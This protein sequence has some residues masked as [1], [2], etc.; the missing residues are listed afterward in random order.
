MKPLFIE[1]GVKNGHPEEI[2]NKI[3][4]D[5]EAF[6]AYA[7]NKS[8]STCYAYIAYQTAYLK[9]H[10]PAEYMASV[11]SNNM[12]D[13]KAIAFFMEEA[14]RMGIKVLG[15]DVNESYYKF[16]VNQEGAIRFGMGAIKGMGEKAV[17]AIINERKKNGKITS[18][19]DMAKRVDLRAASKKAFDGLAVSGGFDGFGNINRSQYYAIDDKGLTILEKA[20]RFGNKFQENKN[21]AQISMFGEASEVQFDEPIIPFCEEWNV[22]EKLS[23]EKEA[24]GMYISGHPLDDYKRELK[25]FCN[26]DISY[27]SKLD[28]LI[29]RDL[30]FGGIV[31]NVQHRISKNGKGWASFVMEDYKE[32]FEFRI[33]GEDYLKFKHFLIP[34]AFLHIKIIVQRGWNDG[35][36]RMNYNNVQM[37]QDILSK[38]AKKITVNIDIDTLT[39]K[40]INVLEDLFIRH[41]G[42]HALHFIVYDK[43]RKLKLNMP[44]RSK[45]VHITTEFLKEMDENLVH[46]K[47]N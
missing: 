42:K 24:I 2:L 8:H 37:L 28:D 39:K 33:F 45:K 18:I 3:W 19:F 1:G 15:P 7:F 17:E 5:W 40:S 27:M 36:A 20:I 30:T 11:L 25:H 44:S 12:R 6:A 46:Y 26:A 14:K 29:G 32:S 23:K 43:E 31:S 22:M 13:I 10:Y 41:S 38:M 9:A 4:K 21:S 34:N 16:S 47:L 35:P